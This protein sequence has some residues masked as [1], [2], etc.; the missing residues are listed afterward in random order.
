[1]YETING[2]KLPNEKVDNPEMIEIFQIQ[3]LIKIK[4]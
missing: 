2:V 1:M 4:K 3:Y